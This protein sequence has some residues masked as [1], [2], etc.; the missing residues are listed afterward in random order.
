MKRYMAI[1][2]FVFVGV[3]A[4]LLVRGIPIV[5]HVNAGGG[6]VA[7]ENG[8]TN[9]DGSRDITDAIYYLTWLFQ[10]GAEPVALAQ[11]V[12]GGLEGPLGSIAES[13]AYESLKN[14]HDRFV[15]NGNDTVTDRLTNLM[16]SRSSVFRGSLQEAQ[17]EASTSN[18][19]GFSDWRL[20]TAAEL[21][22]L[23]KVVETK[24]T[25]MSLQG[26]TSTADGSSHTL[27]PVFSWERVDA[28]GFGEVVNWI[29][30][31]TMNGN[32]EHAF[33]ASF[34][35]DISA[36]RET[37]V[38]DYHD[39]YLNVDDRADAFLVRDN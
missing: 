27:H 24:H 30:S 4:G 10:G 28:F 9:G 36:R 5:L 29:W 18:L 20:P 11:G 26:T 6:A 12:P 32:R 22:T 19:G 1:L 2:G 25:W 34:G 38:S 23:R 33:I 8:D 7:T 35:V 39:R 31:S 16:W 21:L 17:R 15:D 3:L 37:G 13:L 14:R